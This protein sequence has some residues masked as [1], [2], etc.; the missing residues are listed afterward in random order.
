[1]AGGS[2]RLLFAARLTNRARDRR[3]IVRATS[4]TNGNRCRR[5]IFRWSRCR[6]IRAGERGGIAQ[7]PNQGAAADHGDE[8][9]QSDQQ[10]EAGFHVFVLKRCW[11]SIQREL[12]S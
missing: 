12:K 10:A 7:V 1:M 3:F 11:H 9:K 5:R 8:H 4:W 6:G 2:A